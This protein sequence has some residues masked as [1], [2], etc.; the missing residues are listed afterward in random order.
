MFLNIKFSS[1]PV[2]REAEQPLAQ[3]IITHVNDQTVS[4]VFSRR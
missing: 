2:W 4:G 1:F 3:P